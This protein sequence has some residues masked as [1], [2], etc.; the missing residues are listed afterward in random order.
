MYTYTSRTQ[1]T[2]AISELCFQVSKSAVKTF[3][4]DW[5]LPLPLYHFLAKESVPMGEP[6]LDFDLKHKL[7]CDKFG[8][9]SM[10][11]NA[12]KEME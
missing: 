9:T 1:V 8:L 10:I 7:Y 4:I 2:I 5:L 11:D 3:T 6:K 12:H